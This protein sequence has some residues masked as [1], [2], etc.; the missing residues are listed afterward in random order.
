MSSNT[1]D[2]NSNEIS[3]LDSMFDFEDELEEDEL[4]LV[5]LVSTNANDLNQYLVF[6]GSNN[7]WY[8]MNVSKIEEIMV[9]D[10]NI[11][12]VQNNDKE[13]II[14]GTADIRNTMTTLIYFDDWYAN[15]HLDDSEYELIVLAN[16]GGHK[17][18]IIVK[19][20][21]NIST[22]EATKMSDNSQNNAKSTFIAKISVE[23]QEHM[24]TIYDG[25]K[26]LLDIFD[27]IEEQS[28][29]VFN[30]ETIT[31]LSKKVVYF[32]DDSKFVR[33]LVEHLFQ[34]LEMEYKIFND[35]SF[36]IQHLMSHPQSH[37]DLFIT[38]LEMPNSGGREVI[39]N[40]R[41][42]NFYDNVPILVHTNMSNSVMEAEL[43]HIGAN[44]VIGKI[45]M[46]ELSEAMIREICK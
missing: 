17:L 25:D 22:I 43:L 35:G 26:M 34:K 9:Y 30:Q 39:M 40:I 7:E 41:D 21:A 13:T 4:D 19:E 38:D 12:I 32:A 10:E 33:N 16:Y 29:Q 5:K 42:D 2:D 24:C 1:M 11:H 36:L 6:K 44:G 27:S 8:A 46:Q 37:V 18:G 14:F 45:N 20:V 3:N 28:Q 31:A 15:P 23:G